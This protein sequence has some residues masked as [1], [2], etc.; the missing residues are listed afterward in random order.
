MV[1]AL[2][3]LPFLVIG[4]KLYCHRKF[5]DDLLY[6]ARKK[7]K[8]LLVD[9]EAEA[10]GDKSAEN[11][12]RQ[13]NTRFGNPV[14]YKQFM[15][16]MVHAKA[17][18]ALEKILESRRGA[19]GVTGI[20]DPSGGYSD[21]AL[22]TLDP[23]DGPDGKGG[24]R[25]SVRKSI[26]KDF[27]VISENQLDFAYFKDRPEFREEFG[28]EGAMYGYSDEYLPPEAQGAMG[29]YRSATP[30]GLRA[31][32]PGYADAPTPPPFASRTNT[33]MSA[34]NASAAA[35]SMGYNRSQTPTNFNPY[36]QRNVM[37]ATA[38]YQDVRGMGPTLPDVG[39]LST[40]SPY[41]YGNSSQASLTSSAGLL[42][43]GGNYPSRSASPSRNLLSHAD[44]PATTPMH[45]HDHSDNVSADY[46]AEMELQ[47]VAS[48][49]G[50]NG[51]AMPASPLS[52]EPGSRNRRSVA[53]H[54]PLF[55]QRG[56][57]YDRVASRSQSPAPPGTYGNAHPG[58][59][60]MPPN[61]GHNGWY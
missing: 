45:A 19:G 31:P 17:A 60:G 54:G 5:D 27:E 26:N 2:V 14:F 4:F 6:V 8:R 43:H 41:M 20:V 24:K 33:G 38:P 7:D 58:Y 13:L 57:A 3:P 16:P 15:T 52:E 37:P 40:P 47:G 55:D 11:S 53:Q 32:T 46:E 23:V 56:Y 30:T 12:L 22:H 44:M 39:L 1:F 9:V 48:G 36:A 18:D 21:I 10:A 42:R 35:A 28:G 25:E 49:V 34:S 59:Y 50:V 51:P 29:Y 61:R